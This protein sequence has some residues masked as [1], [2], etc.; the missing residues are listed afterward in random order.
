MFDY[1]GNLSGWNFTNY[2][3]PLSWMA[4]S[5]VEEL[6]GYC[7]TIHKNKSEKEADTICPKSAW[8]GN[9]KVTSECYY[10]YWI[11]ESTGGLF[12]EPNT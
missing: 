4:I 7:I 2:T 6:F 5:E 11:E 8:Q 9:C 1:T 12:F 10:G 3:C